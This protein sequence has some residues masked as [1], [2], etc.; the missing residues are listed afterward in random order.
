MSSQSI[1]DDDI[2]FALD[3]VV[4]HVPK[5]CILVCI[6]LGDNQLQSDFLLRMISNLDPIHIFIY[7]DNINSKF[8]K[9]LIKKYSS[10]LT[11]GNTYKSMIIGYPTFCYAPYCPFWVYLDLLA[12]NFKYLTTSFYILGNNLVHLFTEYNTM[13]SPERKVN[14]DKTDMLFLAIRSLVQNMDVTN[15]HPRI[16]QSF[17]Y[18]KPNQLIKIDEYIEEYFESNCKQIEK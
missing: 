14:K 13:K 9:L 11:I 17:L 1:S 15:V 5:K 10:K 2:N 8:K 3:L 12:C 7:D 18:F 16:A 4:N 6:C